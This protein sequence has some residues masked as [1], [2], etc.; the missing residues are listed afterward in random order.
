MQLFKNAVEN[1]IGQL[2]NHNILW[3]INASLFE[4]EKPNGLG[5]WHGRTL[6]LWLRLP[7]KPQTLSLLQTLSRWFHKISKIPM[8]PKMFVVLSTFPN[9]RRSE[10]AEDVEF[11]VIGFDSQS[12]SSHALCPDSELPRKRPKTR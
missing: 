7:A 5:C 2:Q 3:S 4:L 9:P 1:C 12:L 11:K 6:F 10:P 8:M